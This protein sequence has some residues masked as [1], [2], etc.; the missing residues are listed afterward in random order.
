MIAVPSNIARL[1]DARLEKRAVPPAQRPYYKKWLRY[2][3]DFCHKYHHPPAA[4]K[5]LSGFIQKLHEKRQAELQQ[6]QAHQAISIYYELGLSGVH[7]HSEPKTV[8]T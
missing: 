8:S 5:S 2:Y 7:G 1:Y 6:K 3:L 4:K